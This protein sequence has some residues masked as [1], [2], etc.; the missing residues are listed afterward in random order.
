MKVLSVQQPW[1]SAICTGVKDI[2]NR[3]WQPKEAP[4]RIL[5]HASAKKVP[6]NFDE[7]VFNLEVVSALTNMRLFGILPQYGDLPVGAIIGYVDVIGFDTDNDSIWAGVESIH[8]QLENAYLFDEPIEGVKGKL[9]LFDYP[10]D[11]SNLPPAHKVELCYPTLEGNHLTVPLSKEFMEL[12]LDGEKEFTMDMCDPY[13]IETI[14]QEDSFE[15][16]P[17]KKIT[18]TQEGK[19]VTREVEEYGWDA[20]RDANDN[21]IVLNPEDDKNKQIP[22]AYA[23]YKLKV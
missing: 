21:D 10:L 17:V 7:T 1:A 16:K 8:W 19:Q 23:I 12:I 2:E 15:L 14:C 3:T 13:I 11:E 6:K 4:G 22:W 5:I 20:F 9:G 18:F